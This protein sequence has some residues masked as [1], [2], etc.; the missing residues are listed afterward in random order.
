VLVK[1]PIYEQFALCAGAS[2]R[3]TALLGLGAVRS[4]FQLTGRSTG[5]W[6][7]RGTGCLWAKAGSRLLHLKHALK[8]V[9]ESYCL[10]NV[11]FGLR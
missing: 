6:Y 5:Y 2:R 9:D 3:A 8:H 11:E 7:G 10:G 1:G 4:L